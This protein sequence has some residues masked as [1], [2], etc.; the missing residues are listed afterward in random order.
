VIG[1][2]YAPDILLIT[3]ITN[4]YIGT[5]KRGEVVDISVHVDYF[6]RS[7]ICPSFYTLIS[8]NYTIASRTDFG[9]VPRILIDS[10]KCTRG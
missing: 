4:L 3:A 2:Y 6:G 7:F 5:G 9:F 10:G 8:K 1:K